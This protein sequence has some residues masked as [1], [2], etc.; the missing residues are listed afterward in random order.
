M[1]W[2]ISWFI[3]VLSFTG[4]ATPEF[5]PIK[6]PTVRIESYGFSILPP[7]GSGWYRREDI[8]LEGSDIVAIGKQSGSKTHTISVVIARHTGFNPALVGFAEYATNPEVFVAYVKSN[9]LQKN[10]P[11]G[12]MRFLD[13]SA[14]PD[15][16]FGYCVKV[17]A[18]FEDLGSPVAPQ[19]LIQEDWD[20]SCLH[21]DS[22]RV[23]IEIG[24]S[25]RGLP[26]ENDPSLTYIREQF[27]KSFH[28]RPL[29]ATSQ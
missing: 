29:Q 14:V 10:P 21:P 4:C 17:H 12:R 18:K 23:I 13:L 19:I 26:G 6:D 27:F 15:T 11:G 1:R 3:V 22:S 16:E 8:H 2:V 9:A 25:E 20:Y 7:Q 5:V 24:F 28:F